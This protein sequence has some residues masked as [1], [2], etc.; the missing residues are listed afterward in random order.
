MRRRMIRGLFLLG[1][2]GGPDHL[3]SSGLVGIGRKSNVLP[4]AL[5]S[6][7]RKQA[8]GKMKE[9]EKRDALKRIEPYLLAGRFDE[10]PDF[11]Q[12]CETEL[13]NT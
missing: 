10:H 1:L 7:L 5:S 3:R 12:F 4:L 11:M 2:Y 6:V 13:H 8:Y 9:S